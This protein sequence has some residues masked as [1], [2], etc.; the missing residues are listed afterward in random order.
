MASH[1]CKIVCYHPLSVNRRDLLELL[2]ANWTIMCLHCYKIDHSPSALHITHDL[3]RA[4][5]FSNAIITASFKT[6]HFCCMIIA[7]DLL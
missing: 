7:F 3:L 2:N 4:S 6:G 5:P 1:C